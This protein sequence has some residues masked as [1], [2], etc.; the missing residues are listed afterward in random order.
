MLSSLSVATVDIATATTD[1]V[2]WVTLIV[3]L[4]G[5]LALFLLGMDRMTES[6]RLIVG[7]RSR[8]LLEALTTNRFAGLATGAG[9]TAVI[10]SSSVTTVLIVG[11]ISAG[12]M[13]FVQSIP[14]MLGSNIGTTITAQIIAF[15]VTT[16]ALAFVAVGFGISAIAKRQ[17]RAAQ[18]T[19]LMGLGL[20]FFG[21]V[22]MGEAMSPLR[23]YEPFI[24]TMKT[25]DN[26]LLGILAGAL[27]TALIQ[28]SSATT[29]IVIVLA[30]QGLVSPEAGIALVLGANIGTSVTALLA[31]IGTPREAQRA[32]VAHL[33][34][35]VVGVIIWLPLVGWL[36]SFVGSIGGGTAREVA[37]AHTIFNVI[38][39]LIF[40]PFVA[41]FAALVT[42]LVPDRE[43][44]GAMAPKYLDPG[45]VRTPAL[46]LAKARMEMLRMASRVQRML[47]D[48]LPAAIDGTIDDLARIEA[49][50]DEVDSLHGLILEYLGRIG[51]E[52][53][54]E[55][56]SDEL[57][58]LFEA[59]NALEAIGDIIETNLVALGH[60]RIAASV[61]VSPQTRQVITSYHESVCHA[62]ELALIA[63]TQK[64]QN[65]ARRVSHMK[66]EIRELERAA[67]IHETE[68]L[69]A[70]APNR[71]PTYRFETDVLANLK[72]VY[73]F[74]RRIARV[75]V[76]AG[77][78]ASM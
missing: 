9:I 40:L 46:A 56:S 51:R 2:D 34:F 16:W 68:R 41:Q 10:Q 63:V 45:L 24:D 67:A 60:Q 44:E 33:L 47:V 29:G 28:S 35:N 22:V 71:I 69:V 78:Q 62:F 15:K 25:L 20:V 32:A 3:G 38:N 26:P 43:A 72:R 76:P 54:S 31:A 49:M 66:S 61:D 59:T 7:D 65:A 77:E 1:S 21:M 50:D 18:G 55:E 75:A 70:D 14:V 42:R 36:T 6:L 37:N 23:T 73:Y 58:D 4:L 52:K 39:A 30:T 53:L 5:G 74:T 11:F 13:N 57:M 64:D 48:M 27:L 19:A 12:L 17:S 8:R